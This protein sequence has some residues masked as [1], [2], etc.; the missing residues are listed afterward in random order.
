MYNFDTLTGKVIIDHNKCVNCTTHVCVDSCKNYN[1]GILKIA[2]GK[3]VL[4]MPTADAKTGG[5]I[6]CL[7]CELE[8]EEKGKNAIQI[9]LSI[10]P[11]SKK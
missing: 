6:E 1:G 11:P 4:A 2:E 10:P 8:C 3:A 9:I 5:C 7:A